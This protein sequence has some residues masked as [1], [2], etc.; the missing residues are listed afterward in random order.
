MVYIGCRKAFFF[1]LVCCLVVSFFIFVGRMYLL[2]MALNSICPMY[3]VCV[4]KKHSIFI[5]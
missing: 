2:K 1:M 5:E 4:V 3:N